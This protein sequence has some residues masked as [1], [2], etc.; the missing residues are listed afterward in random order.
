MGAGVS[1]WTLARAVSSAGQLGVVSGTA[2]DVI[3]ARRLQLGDLGGHMR[4][5]LDSFPISGVA[6]R[7]IDRYFVPGGKP[8]GKPFRAKPIPTDK[9]SRHLDELLVASNFSE[10]FLAKEGH[11]APVGINY[12]EKIQLPTLPIV[13]R[14]V[15]SQAVLTTC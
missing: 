11:G 8:E 7:I 6:Q 9:P 14:R 12:L 15:Y 3:L 5:A 4:R 1:S 13:V 2:L 10:V